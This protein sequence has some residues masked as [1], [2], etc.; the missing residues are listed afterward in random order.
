MSPASSPRRAQGVIRYSLPILV[1]LIL[2]AAGLIYW[3]IRH[4][5]EADQPAH[6][7]AAAAGPVTHAALGTDELLQRARDA[8]TAQR[9]LAPA[10]NNAFEF[11]LA[12]LQHE[13]GNRVAQD[14]LR[15]IFP[16]AAKGAEQIIDTGDDAEAQR[17]ID[18]LTRADPQNYTLTLLRAKLQAQRTA[19]AQ[20]PP[21]VNRRESM[22]APA[23]KQAPAAAPAPVPVTNAVATPAAKP[24][25]TSASSGQALAQLNVQATPVEAAPSSAVRPRPSITA[26]A[27]VGGSAPVLMHRVEPAY[28]PEAKRT[29]RQGWVDVTFTVQPDG[30]VVGVAVADAEPRYVFDRAALSAVSHWQFSPGTQ[31]GKPVAAQVRQR[32]E[33]RL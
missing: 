11:Y 7:T 17:Q 15:E 33:F 21:A 13:P 18:L 22:P 28:P 30:S 14:A 12:V 3:Q 19:E 6:E 24:A 4:S 10:G 9:L 29:R 25:T 27:S 20:P 32:I 31:D 5:N 26:T 2:V 23:G 16:F 8:M 1:T